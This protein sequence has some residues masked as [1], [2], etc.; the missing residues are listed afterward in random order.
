MALAS[1]F[2]I[3]ANDEHGLNPPTA[4]KRTPIMPYINRSFYENEFNRLCTGNTLPLNVISP[5]MASLSFTFLCVN[6]DVRAVSIVIPAEG[7]SFG[8]APS[9]T[10]I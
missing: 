2:L 6:A 10:W 8:V 4:G 9:G 1:S 5:V 3:A 7:P